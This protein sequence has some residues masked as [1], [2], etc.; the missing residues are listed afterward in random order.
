MT[1]AEGRIRMDAFRSI[2]DEEKLAAYVELAGPAMRAGGA[3]GSWHAGGYRRTAFESGIVER[4]TLIEF[5]SVEAD[6]GRL[7]QAPATQARAA[8]PQSTVQSARSG[9]S[10]RSTDR[11]AARYGWITRQFSGAPRP[12]PYGSPGDLLRRR[13]SPL[14]RTVTA[15]REVVGFGVS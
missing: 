13:R 5:D 4:T 12:L 14:R 3:A 6:C 7:P 9:S 2:T 10:N 1:V 11:A 15:S 8:G